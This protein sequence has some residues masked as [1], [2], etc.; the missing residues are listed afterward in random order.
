MKAYKITDD[1][2]KSGLKHGLLN[3]RWIIMEFGIT[4][5]IKL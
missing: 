2:D 5:I 1:V 3:I 4:L